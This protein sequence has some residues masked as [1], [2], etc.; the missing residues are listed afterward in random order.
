MPVFACVGDDGGSMVGRTYGRVTGTV[1]AT[2][3]TGQQCRGS[4]VSNRDRESGDV[5]MSCANGQALD[6]SFRV[7]EQSTGSSIAAGYTEG[8]DRFIAWS[9][10]YVRQLGISGNNFEYRQMLKA[11]DIQCGIAMKSGL[12]E[13]LV[14][15]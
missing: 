5:T 7:M 6:A 9:G 12:F 10:D 1:M 4:W 8:G 11:G 15:P 14:A 13:R 3:D 2:T